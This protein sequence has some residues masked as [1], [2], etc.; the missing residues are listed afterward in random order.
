MDTSRI[1]EFGITEMIISYRLKQKFNQQLGSNSNDLR[2]YFHRGNGVLLVI[3]T[4]GIDWILTYP[5]ES[6]N[7]RITF[8]RILPSK[9]GRRWLAVKCQRTRSRVDFFR[10]VKDVTNENYKKVSCGW[11]PLLFTSNPSQPHFFNMNKILI[12]AAIV[13]VRK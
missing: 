6:L 3:D 10:H 5:T 8:L 13:A 4:L 2:L 1:I 9:L 12:V 7:R 11:L